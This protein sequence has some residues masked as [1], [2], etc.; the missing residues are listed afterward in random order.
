MLF[1]SDTSGHH[2]SGVETTCGQVFQGGAVIVGGGALET[3]ALLI[4]SGIGLSSTFL[5]YQTTAQRFDRSNCL[6]R[7]TAGP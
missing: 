5:F 1:Q 6:L 4:R 3:L 2:A 7:L